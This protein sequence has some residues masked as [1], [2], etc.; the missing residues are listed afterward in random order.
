MPELPEVHTITNDLKKSI[1]GAQ[2]LDVKIDP[3]YKVIPDNNSFVKLVKGKK[4]TGV[5]RIA[6]NILIELENTGI[7]H[8]HLAMTGRILL[9]D[10]KTPDNWTRVVFLLKADN[11]SRILKFSDMRMF[12]KV[13]FYADLAG[14]NLLKKY[15]PDLIFATPDLDSFSKAIKNK[16]SSIKNVL[17]DQSVVA[18]LG[19]IYATEA[20]FLAG[21]DPS[22]LSNTL[23]KDELQKLLTAAI[24][25][26][27]EGIAHR[28]STL[29][30]KMYVD[31]FGNPG[32]YQEHF[33]IYLKDKCPRCGSGV[34]NTKI[35]GRSTY[36]C[37]SCQK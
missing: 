28:G 35:N 4:I 27:N 24:T 33:K 34:L 2:I 14:S 32:S 30:D 18:G 37:P 6:K 5:S 22:R 11:Y 15:G 12:G 31:I 29:P 1:I 7:L 17:L 25:V 26:L 10:K 21:I 3:Q 9:R 36:H 8:F 19:N 13:G 23:S 20:L 16:K